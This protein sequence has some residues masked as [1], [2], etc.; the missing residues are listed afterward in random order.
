MPPTLTLGLPA[1]PRLDVID[2]EDVAAEL[3]GPVGVRR[4]LARILG[5]ALPQLPV[6][7]AKEKKSA[8]S[9]PNSSVM[10]FASIEQG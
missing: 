7:I 8:R 6:R 2:L 9:D 5:L 4:G 10:F 3:A 1:A